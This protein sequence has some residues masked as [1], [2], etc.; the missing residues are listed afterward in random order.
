MLGEDFKHERKR[1]PT[2]LGAWSI[3]NVVDTAAQPLQLVKLL[4]R[5]HSWMSAKVVV[6]GMESGERELQKQRMVDKLDVSVERKLNK[7]I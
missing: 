2:F 1:R 6:D 4:R 5:W 7:Y 3:D